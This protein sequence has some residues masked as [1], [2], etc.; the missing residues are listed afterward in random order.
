MSLEDLHNYYTCTLL[1]TRWF[2]TDLTV[3]LSQVVSLVLTLGAE[4]AVLAA[5]LPSACSF[6]RYKAS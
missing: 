6:R 4:R 1:S 5:I 3:D 2:S